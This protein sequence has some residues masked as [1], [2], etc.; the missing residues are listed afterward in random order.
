MSLTLTLY[1]NKKLD[2]G[3]YA[4]RLRIYFGKEHF[5]SLGDSA[6]PSEWSKKAGMLNSKAD[7]FES[8]NAFLRKKLKEAQD[9]INQMD[10]FNIEEFKKYFKNGGYQTKSV[11]EFLEEYIE[12]LHNQNKFNRRSD[13][14]TLKNRLF[15]SKQLQPFC[16]KNLLF[17]E[18]NLSFLENFLAHLYA[19][20]VK[21]AA[22]NYLKDL[23]KLYRQAK[24]EGWVHEK[25][26]YPF[27]KF[28][29]G[30]IKSD[31]NPR[32]LS[33]EQLQSFIQINTQEH[34]ELQFAYY[35]FLL[36][37]YLGGASFVDMCHLRYDTNVYNQRIHYTKS[38]TG[39]PMPPVLV[40]EELTFILTQLHSGTGYLIPVLS[41]FHKTPLQ[42]Y[43]RIRKMTNKINR[44]LKKLAEIANI[45]FNLT[46][47]VSR[48]TVGNILIEKGASLRDVQH[49]YNHQRADTTRHYI[50]RMRDDQVS[51]IHKLLKV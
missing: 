25:H 29:F 30:K 4:I 24:D 39:K 2:N 10:V 34:P 43:D 1:K 32:P 15:G 50:L 13:F 38:R 35:T 48:H 16:K 5:V 6:S 47:Y 27:E 46:S 21:G 44:D 37:Y 51:E 33:L 26:K 42:K 23:R 41:D 40:D 12:R 7:N 19:D 8:R 14:K 9:I 36:S 28:D 31:Y 18:I 3:K 45:D 17:T 22:H 49:V 11:Y 20:G